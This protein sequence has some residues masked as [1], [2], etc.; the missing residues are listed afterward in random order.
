VIERRYVDLANVGVIAAAV[1]QSSVIG[2]PA[3]FAR[4][5]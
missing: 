4:A 1:A 2:L 5:I 3:R